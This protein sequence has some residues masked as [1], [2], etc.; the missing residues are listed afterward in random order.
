MVPLP[1]GHSLPPQSQAV[2]RH[3]V[4]GPQFNATGTPPG[5]PPKVPPYMAWLALRGAW[6]K[7]GL[8]HRLVV[9]YEAMVW[10]AGRDLDKQVSLSWLGKLFGTSRQAVTKT[11]V[12]K[13]MICGLLYSERKS[14]GSPTVFAFPKYAEAL[15]R[16]S[17]AF[18]GKRGRKRNNM[19]Q[20]NDIDP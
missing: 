5:D 15:A 16:I 13:L 18:P 10:R 17:M 19:P 1:P 2:T 6:L 11:M 20:N 14:L 12:S 3:E 8:P 7:A 9:C 4:F